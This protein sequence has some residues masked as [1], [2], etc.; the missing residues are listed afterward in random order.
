MENCADGDNVTLYCGEQR[1]DSGEE[2]AGTL[3]LRRM[4]VNII[5]RVVRTQGPSAKS[6][7][8]IRHKRH[9]GKP[10]A[11]KLPS[12]YGQ[13]PL[14]TRIPGLIDEKPAE[15]S[16][17]FPPVSDGKKPKPRIADI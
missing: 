6:K 4:S 7:N 13:R 16:A 10:I 14:A 11:T 1:I 17:Y 9:S 3:E 5:V 8:S 15:L 2:P 12:G